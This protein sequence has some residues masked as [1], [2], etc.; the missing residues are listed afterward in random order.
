[1]L[2]AR[3]ATRT[4]VEGRTVVFRRSW[5]HNVLYCKKLLLFRFVRLSP[6]EVTVACWH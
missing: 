1:M 2:L 6:P 3:K 5:R 4:Q